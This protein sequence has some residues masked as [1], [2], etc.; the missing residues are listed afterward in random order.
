MLKK[1]NDLKSTQHNLKHIEDY[2]TRR[3]AFT[4]AMLNDHHALQPQKHL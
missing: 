3:G 2:G 4:F 1:T